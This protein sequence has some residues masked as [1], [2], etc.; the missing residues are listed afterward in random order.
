[1]SSK[2]VRNYQDGQIHLSYCVNP[3]LLSLLCSLRYDTGEPVW[4]EGVSMFES[5]RNV[6]IQF[7]G[8][9]AHNIPVG[10]VVHEVLVEEVNTH[11]LGSLWPSSSASKQD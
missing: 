2:L 11:M 4:Y 9:I 8:G 1:M 3:Y 7:M 6:M 5:A 10:D